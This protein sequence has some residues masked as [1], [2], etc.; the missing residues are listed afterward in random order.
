MKNETKLNLP[1]YLP[2]IKALKNIAA[3]RPDEHNS[4][5]ELYE[6]LWTA[7]LAAEKALLSYPEPKMK[8]NGKEG[9][10]RLLW[11]SRVVELAELLNWGAY[12][13]LSWFQVWDGGWCFHGKPAVTT[14]QGD[15]RSM[16]FEV[17]PTIRD[18]GR[19]S[20]SPLKEFGPPQAD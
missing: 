11:L 1:P 16:T 3:I 17:S 2:A 14:S 6:V 19:P 12:E 5:A 8:W 10:K 4:E 18:S 7:V 15:H 9:Q 13:N 20:R